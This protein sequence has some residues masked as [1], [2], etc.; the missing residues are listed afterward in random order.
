MKRWKSWIILL[1]MIVICMSTFVACRPENE[2]EIG[3]DSPYGGE[4]TD[5]SGNETTDS[6]GNETTDPSGNMDNG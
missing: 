3:W 1:M 5:P 2:D 4:T 6:S